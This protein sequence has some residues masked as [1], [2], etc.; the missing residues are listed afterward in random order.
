MIKMPVRRKICKIGNGLAIFIP[1]SWISLLEAKHGSVKAVTMEIDGK[2]IIS[3]ILEDS[4][5]Q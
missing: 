3:P 5:N 1:K 2:L 4:E